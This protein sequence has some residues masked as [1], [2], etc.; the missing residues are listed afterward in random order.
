MGR[1]QAWAVA[2][3]CTQVACGA[4]GGRQDSGAGDW[5]PPAM[6]TDDG[7][8]SGGNDPTGDD[9]DDGDDGP[10]PGSDDGVD[11]DGAD[12]DGPLG[13]DPISF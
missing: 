4:E 9:D 11:D 7:E 5:N 6:P 8:E 10:L 13:V 3:S 12:D 1:A 2:L